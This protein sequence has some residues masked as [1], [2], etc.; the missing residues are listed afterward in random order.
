MGGLPDETQTGAVRPPR[1]L[2]AKSPFR[3]TAPYGGVSAGFLDGPSGHLHLQPETARRFFLS[4]VYCAGWRSSRPR[5][6][7]ARRG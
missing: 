2:A 4:F 3:G 6:R 7:A 5:A 1:N